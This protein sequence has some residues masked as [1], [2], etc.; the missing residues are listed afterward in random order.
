MHISY[1]SAGNGGIFPPGIKKKSLNPLHQEREKNQSGWFC[2][3]DSSYYWIRREV[4]KCGIIESQ[5]KEF[6]RRWDISGGGMLIYQFS[7]KSRVNLD[8]KLF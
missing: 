4:K 3:E 5:C 8:T 6:E 7:L 1:T 2:L